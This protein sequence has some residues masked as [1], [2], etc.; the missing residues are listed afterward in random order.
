MQAKACLPSKPKI[1]GELDKP[2]PCVFMSEKAHQHLGV[3][4]WQYLEKFAI[5]LL[6][7]EANVV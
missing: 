7:I 1:A 4:F 6:I 3:P 5:S 2:I